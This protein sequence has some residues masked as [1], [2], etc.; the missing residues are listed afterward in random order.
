MKLNYQMS[1]LSFWGIIFVV[2]GHI[3][4][5][6]HNYAIGTFGGWFPYY[7]FHMPLFLFVTGYFYKEISEC[8]I[9]SFIRKKLKTLLVP[10][11]FI[12]GIFLLFQ[13]IL[14]NYG[15]EIGRIFSLKTWL[16]FPWTTL[17][18][19]TFS[20]PTW[21]LIALFIAEIYFVVIRKIYKKIIKSD[22]IKELLL[23]WTFFIGGGGDCLDNLY[24]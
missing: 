10:Y 21:Y 19:L 4:Q 15:F 18:P 9:Y 11:F 5:I 3:N 17:Q 22:F 8:V 20:I 12:N 1:L 14:R 23:L 13:T 16:I 2:L 6:P 7:S 24:M